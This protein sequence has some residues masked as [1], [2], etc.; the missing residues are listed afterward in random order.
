MAYK[1]TPTQTVK[2]MLKSFGTFTKE[3]DVLAKDKKKK[4]EAKKL[5]SDIDK[6]GEKIGQKLTKDMQEVKKSANQH[7]A[8]IDAWLGDSARQVKRAQSGLK[9]YKATFMMPEYN[10]AVNPELEIEDIVDLAKQDALE[11]GKSWFEY[12][13]LNPKTKHLDDKHL[14]DFY[15]ARTGIMGDQKGYL[16]KIKKM[17]SLQSLAGIVAKEAKSMSG[18][19]ATDLSGTQ[20]DVADLAK[21]IAGSL[22]DMKDRQGKMVKRATM[23]ENIAALDTLGQKEFDTSRSSLQEMIAVHKEIKDQTKTLKKELAAESKSIDKS[24]LKD[25]KIS[26]GLKDSKDGIAA[27]EDLVKPLETAIKQGAVALKDIQKKVP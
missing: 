16:A 21:K 2:V 3:Y 22:K 6:K 26:Q 7:F 23:I 11:F 15:K 5:K 19:H 10:E 17:Q 8:K 24:F 27:A 9:G 12:R 18:S 14:K 4:K 13:G 1:S 25:P 20:S